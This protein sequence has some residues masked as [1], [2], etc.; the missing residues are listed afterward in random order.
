M[1]QGKHIIE[2]TSILKTE[3]RTE[4]TF[5]VDP[6]TNLSEVIDLI[7][8]DAIINKGRC[9]IGGTY[10]EI[11]AERNSIIVVPTN[12][13]IDNKCFTEDGELKPNH[14]PVRGK[15]QKSDFIALNNFMA[16]RDV[17]KKIFC[18]PESLWKVTK[19]NFPLDE[20]YK[21]W[22]ILFD[23]AHTT[24]TDSFRKN[25]L[26]AFEHFFNFENKALISATPYYFSTPKLKLFN[27]YNIE[28]TKEGNSIE[29]HHAENVLALLHTFLVNPEQSTGRVHVFLNSVKEIANAINKAEIT[30]CS[31]FCKYD[32]D[33]M[34][35]LDELR[36]YYQDAPNEATF[37]KFNFYTS[38]YYEG[39][40]LFDEGATI[41]IVSDTHNQ[42]LQTGISNKCVQ[43]AG[44]NRKD[45]ERIIH[46]TT[47]RNI[48]NFEP[49]S[50]IEASFVKLGNS[51]IQRY[52][53][54]KNDIYGIEVHSKPLEDVVLLYGDINYQDKFATYNDF[55][56]DQ[57]V[58]RE[59][60]KQEY[61]H[62][63]FIKQAWQNAWY[64]VS[65]LYH[66]YV[67]NISEN[68]NTKSQS[69][70]I[71]VAVEFLESLEL[72]DNDKVKNYKEM[73]KFL[74][75]D[76]EFVRAYFVELGGDAMRKLDFNPQSIK[77]AYRKSN[78]ERVKKYIIRDYFDIIGENTI[79]KEEFNIV[80]L[81]LYVKYGVFKPNEPKNTYMIP[82]VAEFKR[83]FTKSITT[84]T[85]GITS[86][87]F[88][89]SK[90]KPE[91]QYFEE[92]SSL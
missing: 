47:D 16:N 72:N 68:V 36:G 52:N 11:N 24:I 60:S 12:A 62:V 44:R 13:I 38:K 28:F 58:N 17:N 4:Y 65:N 92:K 43:A 33:N 25:I 61:N 7:P 21:S 1:I 79:Y 70:K 82:K 57:W 56:T 31:V 40:D 90:V 19:C 26:S 89:R 91:Y 39:W 54:H 5:E 87:K 15:F 14:Y 85:D 45:S 35:K 77:I 83:L 71:K 29:I 66:Y 86:Y 23:E 32:N 48:L 20:L 22:F 75:I 64:K 53:D 10:L 88:M 49:F 67:P 46:I 50:S 42:S 6:I 37:S 27:Q 59:M 76:L 51:I 55:K 2:P 80:M 63:N 30:D 84:K 34:E 74:P 81:D 3:F 18:T 78:N 41:I 9:G 69:H 73:M 8:T